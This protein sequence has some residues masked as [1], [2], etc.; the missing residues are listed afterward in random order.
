MGRMAVVDF[1]F[2]P[3]KRRRHLQFHL[4]SLF[5]V[6]E[7]FQEYI[8]CF[9]LRSPAITPHGLVVSLIVEGV[10]QVADHAALVIF[11]ILRYFFFLHI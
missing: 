3:L 11:Q 6:V 1:Q 2:M 8:Q 7:R 10:C 4:L 9:R 5:L